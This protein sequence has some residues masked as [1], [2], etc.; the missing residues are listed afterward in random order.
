MKSSLELTPTYVRIVGQESSLP[1]MSDNLQA[2]ATRA[3]EKT[4]ANTDEQVFPEK[5]AVGLALRPGPGPDVAYI[6]VNQLVLWFH[7]CVYLNRGLGKHEDADR[8]LYLAY[9]F[10]YHK[11]I[12]PSLLARDI[13]I[14]IMSADYREEIIRRSSVSIDPRRFPQG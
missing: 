7:A 6:A 9:T 5:R 8:S 3:F 4:F 10:L 14:Q 1:W 13:G 2:L 12:F 11:N